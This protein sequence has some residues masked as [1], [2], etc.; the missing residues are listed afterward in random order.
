[1]KKL[2]F[3]SS[4]LLAVL[5]GCGKSP[6]DTPTPEPEPEPEPEP[7]TAVATVTDVL[8]LTPDFVASVTGIEVGSK[9]NCGD[10]LTLKL[11][12]GEILYSG[13]SESHMQHLFIHV[14]DTVYVPT[15]PAA[16]EE[17]VQ[18]LPVSIVVPDT[19]S[20]EVD[21]VYSVQQQLSENGA[22]LRLVDTED[23]ITL[24]GV[25]PDVK[26]KYFDCYLR[27]P[28]SYTIS[29]IDVKI[30][31]GDWQDIQNLTGCSYERTEAYDW[32]YNVTIR[33]DYEDLN[34]NVQI[35]VKGE[36]HDRYNISW[37]GT[38]YIRTDI[39]E[40][41]I[42]ND[43]PTEA[44]DGE[45]VTA[46]FYTVDSHY[47]D[48]ATSNIE[49]LEIN[50]YSRAYVVFTMPASDVEINLN[51]LK[52][53]SVSY[54]ESKNIT[55]AAIYDKPDLYYGVSTDVGIPG[56][57]VYLFANA[58]DGYKPADAVVNGAS[59]KFQI[60][61][62][63]I[64]TYAYYAAVTLP[65]EKG[66]F[67]I[68][69]TAV[70]AYSVSG[71]GSSTF[72]FPNGSSWAEGDTV[73]FIVY[74]PSGKTLDS[75][76]GITDGGNSVDIT[77]D[78]ANGT[79]TMPA[80]NVTLSAK[81][82]DL[83]E[84][85]T[86]H[87]SAIFDEEEYSVYSQTDPYYRHIDAEGFDAPAGTALYVY[88][89]DTYSV[90]FWV[91][92]K[93]GDEVYYYEATVDPDWGDVSFGKTFVFTDDTVFKIGP[94]KES[95]QFEDDGDKVSVK[96]SYDPEEFIVKSYTDFNWD[97]QKG[98][99]VEKD[100]NFSLNVQ[101]MYGESFWVGIKIGSEVSALQAAQDEETGEYLFNRSI[102]ASD[103]VEIKVGYSATSV[104][105]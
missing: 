88:I 35:R 63:G 75:V 101:N 9:Y 104:A 34:E 79:F 28:D 46:V 68:S 98:F 10:T 11:T 15:F 90:P 47:L 4:I 18:S 21:V 94:T 23:D 66:P 36:Q 60:Y 25:H 69:A 72:T 105:F 56:E 40:D 49:G 54:E 83:D 41:W 71:D 43:L 20:F 100:S 13:F 89:Y 62:E 12:P 67:T 99:T 81:F 91:G 61:G 80:D 92:V 3:I 22:T 84:G 38:E 70:K 19:D 86:V 96:A 51:F 24:L 32:L 102:T 95:V 93:M 26:Y 2:L 85:N 27:T 50:C 14:A 39:P 30:G 8:N 73:E 58:A 1:M 48:G 44:I 5:T 31:E 45:E 57:E 55:S 53:A 77:M 103:D 6:A 33:P 16:A 76:S 17:Y 29:R 82:S 65:E 64:D 52:K 59:Y 7:I 78:N 87:I 42:Q 97:F 37:K 74:V